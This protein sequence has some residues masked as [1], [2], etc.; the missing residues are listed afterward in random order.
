MRIRYAFLAAL[1]S[2]GAV[3]AQ[4]EQVLSAI[5][6]NN[7]DIRSAAQQAVA[8]QAEVSAQNRLNDPTI[9]F[10][11]LWREKSARDRSYELTVS[12]EFDFPAVYAYRGKVLK[13]TAS[14]NEARQKALRQQVLLRAKELC[15]EIVYLNKQLELT[16][17]RM[18]MAEMLDR[19]YRSK[20]EQGDVCILDANKIELELL[21]AQVNLQTLLADRKARLNELTVLNGGEPLA[22][23]ADRLDV[24]PEEVLP[25]SFDEFRQLYLSSDP[26]LQMLH[27]EK[28]LAQR[29]V[30]LSKSQ[31]WPSFELGYRHTSELGERFH[32]LAVGMTLPV[33]ANRKQ[34]KAAK[35]Q[36]LYQ[37]MEADNNVLKAVSDMQTVYEETVSLKQSFD[38]YQ[39]LTRQD[40]Y[41]LLAK[42]LD[43][44]QISLVE[45][46]LDAAQL[47]EAY[48]NQLRLEYQLQLNLAR[49]YRFKL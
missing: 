20:L 27:S 11:H 42:A 1:C 3:S 16:R 37:S 17:K 19:S 45:Y 33:F 22:D 10:E 30:S 9:E 38:R 8:S 36:A 14:L 47:Y 12:Q 24:Y 29:E 34:V 5:E 26:E 49:L 40:N 18:D 35:A 21:N 25:A 23:A 2:A 44:G 43:A 7:G 41:S 48:D 31:W 13:A 15:I 6:Q 4:T 39:V 46:L 28:S 32:G